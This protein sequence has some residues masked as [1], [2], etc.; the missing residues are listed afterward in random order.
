MAEGVDA[1]GVVAPATPVQALMEE[2]V[3]Q[4]ERRVGDPD[5]PLPFSK[6]L[7]KALLKVAR[8]IEAHRE[9]LPLRWQRLGRETLG[10]EGG[11]L[12]AFILQDLEDL[13]LL[14]L[15]EANGYLVP[16]KERARAMAMAG[17]PMNRLM[18]ALDAEGEVLLGLL[19]ETIP[20]GQSL[21]RCTRALDRLLFNRTSILTDVYFEAFRQ[22]TKTLRDVMAEISDIEENLW[23]GILKMAMTRPDPRGFLADIYGRY[24]KALRLVGSSEPHVKKASDLQDALE[25]FAA[26]IRQYFGCQE[27]EY[28]F[29]GDGDGIN[30]VV[31]PHCFYAGRCQKQIA[32]GMPL[33]CFKSRAMV[34]FIPEELG[35]PV[36][37]EPLA[38]EPG[39]RC[40]LR[41]REIQGKFVAQ[42]P[43]PQGP[44]RRT[45]TEGFLSALPP[46]ENP[47][48][49][50]T[51]EIEALH[52]AFERLEPYLRRGILEWIKLAGGKVNTKEMALL[53]RV[54]KVDLLELGEFL[55]G[56]E[57]ERYLQEWGDFALHLADGGVPL[58]SL[59]KTMKLEEEAL[60]PLLIHSNPSDVERVVRLYE[61]LGRDRLVVT[62]RVYREALRE[63]ALNLA[64]VVDQY[65]TFTDAVWIALIQRANEE[66]DPIPF[67]QAFM[68]LEFEGFLAAQ[69]RR[70]P[71]P[72]HSPDL[73]HVVEG[74]VGWMKSLPESPAYRGKVEEVDDGVDITIHQG[75]PNEGRCKAMLRQG[76]PLVCVEGLYFRAYA[77]TL[78]HDVVMKQGLLDPG[79]SCHSTLLENRNSGRPGA[80]TLI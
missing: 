80:A 63:D 74:M 47:T 58:S 27:E 41:A 20:R 75:C 62:A 59:V 77:R 40:L 35:R 7:R 23:E 55:R 68:D 6:S 25:I 54:V 16:F 29:M 22:G 8:I 12:G 44:V 52:Q 61:R 15:G 79:R 10:D 37:V 2:A 69:A 18:R 42:P 48:R 3:L 70:R 72:P 78:G 43:Q 17:T 67:L 13:Q 21:W 71:L 31:G 49:M 56:G 45:N 36:A 38:L 32:L 51:S 57:V 1:G 34:E 53:Y 26:T 33:F 76:I 4:A 73:F 5:S 19:L 39:R 28:G 64:K 46:L 30:V 24:L 11:Q 9:T 50:Y 60:L 66:G 65:N 14:T